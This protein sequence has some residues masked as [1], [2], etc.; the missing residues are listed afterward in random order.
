ML[1]ACK[2]IFILMYLKVCVKYLFKQ[3]AREE[4]LYI[5]CKTVV[6]LVFHAKDLVNIAQA[7]TVFIFMITNCMLSNYHCI[8]I[9]II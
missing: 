6:D 1:N 2:V 8:N 5:L 9:L 3:E 4:Y 7:Y